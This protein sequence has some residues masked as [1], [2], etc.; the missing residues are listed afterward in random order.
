MNENLLIDDSNDWSEFFTIKM[1]ILYILERNVTALLKI[2]I[3]T[4]FYA[5]ID[6]CANR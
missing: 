3:D 1:C 4:I 6:R 2:E 5:S